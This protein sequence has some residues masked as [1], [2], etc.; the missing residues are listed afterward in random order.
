MKNLLFR[1]LPAVA[2]LFFISQIH[3]QVTFPRNGVYDE[4]D[5]VYAFT[6]ATIYTGVGEPLQKATLL[7]RKGRIEQIGNAVTI[8]KEAIV[9]DCK[10]KCIYPSF[11]DMYAQY[12]MP[13]VPKALPSFGRPQFVSNK[14]GAFSWNEALRSEFNASDVFASSDKDA[15]TFR[16]AGFGAVLSHRADGISRGSGILV[17]TSSAADQK[18]F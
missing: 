4:R 12:G 6:N 3:A 15:E 2:F 8:P 11:I 17:T 1:L 5:G 13:E 14:K 7:I 9:Y 16:A 18:I 10:D